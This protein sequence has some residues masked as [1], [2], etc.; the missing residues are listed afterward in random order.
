MATSI[1]PADVSAACSP[2]TTAQP[3]PHSG[4]AGS[5]Q[6]GREQL[7]DVQAVAAMLGCSSRH[8]YRLADGG[9]MPRPVKIGAL[10][11]WPLASIQSWIDQ[12]CPSV[13][14]MRGGGR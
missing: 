8:V 12:S 1:L 14:M 7:L 4:N 3:V 6:P 10:C 5:L 9:K 11:R 13:R 2:V